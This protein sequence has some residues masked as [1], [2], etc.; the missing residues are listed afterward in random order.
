MDEK[1]IQSKEPI[2]PR[3]T[4]L[5][6]ILFYAAYFGLQQTTMGEGLI[7][8]ALGLAGGIFLIWGIVAVIKQK[9]F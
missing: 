9:R 6:M 2:K 4:F 7:A 5:A 8:T 3:Y 1:K